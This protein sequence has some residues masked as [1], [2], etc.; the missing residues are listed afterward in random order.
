MP[1]FV[2]VCAVRVMVLTRES[3]VFSWCGVR[4]YRKTRHDNSNSR[5]LC[6]DSTREKKRNNQ[7]VLARERGK[8]WFPEESDVV[9][10][11]WNRHTNVWNHQA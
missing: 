2:G 7:G 6:I 9:S 11:D 10:G 4:F 8:A 3:G 5:E 1:C